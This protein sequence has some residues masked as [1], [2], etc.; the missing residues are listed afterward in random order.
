MYLY[1]NAK[2]VQPPK[3]KQQGAS[4]S[5]TRGDAFLFVLMEIYELRGIVSQ[6]EKGTLQVQA[7]HN[8]PYK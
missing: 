4:L 2:K 7:Y 8:L 3:V 5:V 6:I 1:Y